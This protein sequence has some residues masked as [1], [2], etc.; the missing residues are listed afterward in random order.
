MV[1]IDE[2]L[3]AA[4]QYASSSESSRRLAPEVLSAMREAG[5]FR[6]CVPRTLDGAE[7]DP[8]DVLAII[9]RVAVVDGSA[10]WCAMIAATSGCVSGHLR[11]DIA[12]EIYGPDDALV[13]GPF[14]PVGYGRRDG[15]D[16]LVTGR[17]P[18]TS[19]CQDSSWIMAGTTV[20][21]GQRMLMFIPTAQLRIHDTWSVMGLSATGSHDVEAVGVPV[22]PERSVSLRFDA[23][24]QP[25]PLY[26]FPVLAMLAAGVATVALGIARGAIDQLV[27]LAA[28]KTP[29]YSVRRLSE[30]P[31]TQAAVARAESELRSA[32]AWLFGSVRAAWAELHDQG[33]IGL[34]R[35]VDLR[36]AATHA[37][38]RAADVVTAMFT[39]GGG[40]SVYLADPAQRRLRDVHTATQHVMV[41]PGVLELAGRSL[42]GLR[43]DPTQL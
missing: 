32:R 17:W 10:G 16:Y 28:R 2:V 39:A 36:M 24:F 15:D 30:R 26:S 1:K 7:L 37:T 8:P 33:A 25:G 41:G 13:V 9:E 43:I 11:P 35:R 42:L 6:V 34:D 19:L 27:E 18:Y 22:A 3:E 4:R 40:S 29:S 20:D 5:L 14:A 38:T 12:E 23:P 21:D 31:T